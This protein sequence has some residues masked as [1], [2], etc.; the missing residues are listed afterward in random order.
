V[1][2]HRE[3]FERKSRK[4]T[5]EKPGRAGERALDG[6]DGPAGEFAGLLP[7]DWAGTSYILSSDLAG[8]PVTMIDDRMRHRHAAYVI[9]MSAD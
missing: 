8:G 5:I 2:Y 3:I 9:R 6:A 1:I 4:E 7:P